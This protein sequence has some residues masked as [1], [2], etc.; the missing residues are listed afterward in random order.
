M[1]YKYSLPTHI[2]AFTLIE[3]LVSVTVIMLVILGPLSVAITSSSYSKNTKDVIVSTYLAQEG[4]ELIRFKRDS[5]F[6]ECLNNAGTCVPEPLQAGVYETVREAGWRLFKERLGPYASQPSCFAVDN[7]V[8]CSFDIYGFVTTGSNTGERYL[9][10]DS[11]CSYLVRDDRKDAVPSGSNGVTD[12]VY[13]CSVTAPAFTQTTFNRSIKLTSVS[14]AGVSVYDREY[15]DD[16]RVEST[17]TYSR[18]NGIQ[19][20]V[21]VVDYLHARP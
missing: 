7:A 9:S 2:H 16:L 6:L 3:T 18:G 20:T 19:R 21:R 1:K 14:P 15:H 11:K 17:I 10:T 12:Y 13:V 4:L 8:G 5:T